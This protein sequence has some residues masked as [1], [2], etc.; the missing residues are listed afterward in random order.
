MRQG[1]ASIRRV[2]GVN[3]NCN[4]NCQPLLSW[5]PLPSQVVFLL[6]NMFFLFFQLSDSSAFL[7]NSRILIE[8]CRRIAFISHLFY[9]FCN[10]GLARKIH[11]VCSYRDICVYR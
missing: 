8:S 6:V 10:V 1:C 9:R 5:T 3:V 2:E 4:V 7:E 11:M